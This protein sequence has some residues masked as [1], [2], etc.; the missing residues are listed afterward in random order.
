MDA[1]AP[2]G[3]FHQIKPLGADGIDRSC[4][5]APDGLATS[6]DKS[7]SAGMQAL[8]RLGRAVSS[9]VS[10]GPSGCRLPDRPLRDRS[11]DRGPDLF[12]PR[13]GAAA[14]RGGPV[15]FRDAETARV[16]AFL[17]EPAGR[18]A[19]REEYQPLRAPFPVGSPPG[20]RTRVSGAGCRGGLVEMQNGG[21]ARQKWTCGGLGIRPPLR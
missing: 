4:I 5:P 6:S 2:A 15:R 10:L 12:A 1:S 8:A 13:A 14:G 11:P 21:S 20:L 18:Q 17:E 19:C 16:A 3:I 7:F 9:A